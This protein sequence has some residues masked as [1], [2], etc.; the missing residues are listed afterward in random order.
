LKEGN[1]QKKAVEEEDEYQNVFLSN[2]TGISNYFLLYR[3]LIRVFFLL[4]LLAIP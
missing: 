4:S 3:H 1:A 2:G